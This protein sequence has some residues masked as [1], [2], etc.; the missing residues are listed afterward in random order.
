M[1]IMSFIIKNKSMGIKYFIAG[2]AGFIGSTV[3]KSLLKETDTEAITIYDNFSSGSEK[4]IGE[5]IHNKKLRIVKND[6][7]ELKDLEKEMR[8]HDFV[9]HFASNPDIA[10]AV[11]EPDIDFWQGTYLTQNIVEAMRRNS[12]LKIVYA[13]GSGVYGETG[14]VPVYESM[15]S[16][17][18]ISTYG[19]S[20]LAGEAL[21]CAYAHMFDMDALAFRFANVIGPNQTHGVGYDFLRK[22]KQNP[23][24]L[25]ILGDGSQSK[26]Y[27]HVEDVIAGINVAREKAKGRFNVFNLATPDY[28][29]VK[30]IAEMVVQVMNIQNVQFNFSGGDRGWKG[31]VPIV[32]F[33]TSLIRSLG[34]SPKRSTREAM[35]DALLSMKKELE[36]I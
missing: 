26:S 35:M 17:S 32:R 24:E 33:D 4:N 10:R 31:D 11:K 15:G 36:L 14:E 28:L 21:L 3:T 20:K 5:A 8:G 19:A 25:T 12:V 29:T 18:P 13:S 1:I 16:L 2:G 6:I 22:L 23:H 34:W 30:E 7:G 27:L 9:Y